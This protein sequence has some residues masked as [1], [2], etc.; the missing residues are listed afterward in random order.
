MAVLEGSVAVC[1]LEAEIN[2]G[3]TALHCAAM[4][5]HLEVCEYLI[6]E[7]AHVTLTNAEN[8]T[9]LHYIVRK[10]PK[11]AQHHGMEGR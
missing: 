9:P 7:G 11:K 8:T 3:S 4:G 5:P 10:A 1:G 2:N 6:N